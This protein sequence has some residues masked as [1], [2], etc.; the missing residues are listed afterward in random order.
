MDNYER[1]LIFIGITYCIPQ[2]ESIDRVI[3]IAEP[4]QVF[5]DQ[6]LDPNF[7]NHQPDIFLDVKLVNINMLPEF[8]Y[9]E[10]RSIFIIQ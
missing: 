7:Q 6:M 9:E 10:Y 5:I 3:D 1:Q 2:E 4:V 8:D